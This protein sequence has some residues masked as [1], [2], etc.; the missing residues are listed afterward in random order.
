MQ[1]LI[2]E[3]NPC[4][5]VDHRAHRGAQALTA[6]GAQGVK[7]V[8][9]TETLAQ[10]DRG[11]HLTTILTRVI[12]PRLGDHFRGLGARPGVITQVGLI[13]RNKVLVLTVLI[14]LM[15]GM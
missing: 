8:P 2:T 5:R 14:L 3:D 1:M 4:N 15:V 11:P 12:A 10:W 9:R 6:N 13:L 7:M